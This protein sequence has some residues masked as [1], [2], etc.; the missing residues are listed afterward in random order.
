MG[1]C[2]GKTKI[3]VSV[4]RLLKGDDCSPCGPDKSFVNVLCRSVLRLSSGF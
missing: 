4:P 2:R 1:G 3:M